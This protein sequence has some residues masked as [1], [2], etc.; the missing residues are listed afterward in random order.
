[1]SATVSGEME[2]A[3]QT[4]AA[5]PARQTRENGSCRMDIVPPFLRGVFGATAIDSF[6]IKPA[7][8]AGVFVVG[9]LVVTFGPL[10]VSSSEEPPGQRPSPFLCRERGKT[11]QEN[12][13]YL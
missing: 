11:K 7:H 13:K 8:S 12:E 10:F 6:L 9:W 3:P 1:M 2:S 4:A 5:V